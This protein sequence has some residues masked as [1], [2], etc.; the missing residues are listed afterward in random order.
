MN[1]A[2]I[3][4][5]SIIT[6]VIIGII[7]IVVLKSDGTELYAQCILPDT[8]CIIS[9]E[10]ECINKGGTWHLD[11][12]CP[13]ESA[14]GACCINT[15]NGYICADI[16]K[17][18]CNTNNG[19]FYENK[20]CN[21]FNCIK[22]NEYRLQGEPCDQVLEC[23]NGLECINFTCI[24]KVNEGD[25]CDAASVC[26]DGLKCV[27]GMCIHYGIE[28]EYCEV[29]SECDPELNLKCVNNRCWRP[30]ETNESCAINDDCIDGL[31]CI[32][33]KCGIHQKEGGMCDN[34]A[35]CMTGLYCLEGKC[36]KPLGS[37]ES[38]NS[39][40]ECSLGLDCMPNGK[41]GN[42]LPQGSY[43]DDD[44]YC[45]NGLICR[46]NACIKPLS[47]GD[48]CNT[49][50]QCN[51]GYTCADKSQ[52]SDYAGEP[53]ICVPEVEMGGACD[54]DDRCEEG[55]YCV[56]GKCSKV[57]MEGESCVY[58]CIPGT[59][60]INNVCRPLQPIGGVCTT[61]SHCIDY[62]SDK[63]VPVECQS[64][65][66]TLYQTK[67]PC[68]PKLP[69]KL[70]QTCV[71]NT[72]YTTWADSFSTPILSCSSM[73][74]NYALLRSIPVGQYLSHRDNIMKGVSDAKKDCTW[75]IAPYGNGKFLITTNAKTGYCFN[76]TL[77]INNTY[78]DKN[79]C[80]W[81]YDPN[82][83]LIT[84]RY[85]TDICLV[86]NATSKNIITGNYSWAG[87]AKW[88]IIF[89]VI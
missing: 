84:N 10:S 83:K 20:Q 22:G 85:Y 88:D 56:S 25:N 48:V 79:D 24:K 12:L 32:N 41:C 21:N 9:S 46:D 49:R 73:S 80:Q 14:N 58:P 33:G 86:Q 44:T 27:D 45:E 30:R 47:A 78:C 2:I 87:D 43:C 19:T 53:K 64:G 55:L 61:T 15:N 35:N 13:T 66:C 51:F 34:D 67:V 18:E 26:K 70:G 76:N 39:S 37:G 50:N 16:T 69:C 17:S 29:D 81:I 31:D 89:T 3:L 4:V 74:K 8:N 6:V 54:K 77:W 5:I 63:F 28:N 82:T 38:C 7:I 57:S 36:W 71:Y 60:C 23:K 65:K 40:L 62:Y 75:K 68:D 59:V 42:Y 72:Q 1:P 11:R 52:T